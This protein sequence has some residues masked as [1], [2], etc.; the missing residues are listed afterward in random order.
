MAAWL[1]PVLTAWSA[2][3][4]QWRV[5]PGGAV[6]LDYPGA[7]VALD[8]YRIDLTAELLGDLQTLEHAALQAWAD[9]R[10]H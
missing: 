9:K 2:I 4:T 8:A 3:A 6:G 10:G 7:K 1:A 5:G